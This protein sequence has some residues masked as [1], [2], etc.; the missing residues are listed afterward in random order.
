MSGGLDLTSDNRRKII[1]QIILFYEEEMG[2]SD[3][4]DLKD[5]EEDLNLPSL[6]NLNILIKMVILLYDNNLDKL[7]QMYENSQE[8]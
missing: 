4:I 6:F 5:E 7:Y 2:R 1:R 8:S 3:L